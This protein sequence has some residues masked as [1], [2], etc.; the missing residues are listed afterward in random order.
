MASQVKLGSVALAV[1]LCTG[2][3]GEGSRVTQLNTLDGMFQKAVQEAA[4]V[5]K[6]QLHPCRVYPEWDYRYM[7]CFTDS[8]GSALPTAQRL[9]AA[10]TGA[11]FK[12]VGSG[13]VDSELDRTF[14]LPGSPFTLNMSFDDNEFDWI[15]YQQDVGKVQARPE[16][17]ADARY[18]LLSPAQMAEQM[19]QQYLRYAHLT[20]AQQNQ[21]VKYQPCG[22]STATQASVC[23]TMP[24]T[25]VQVY[26]PFIDLYFAG[27]AAEFQS[28]NS[29]PTFRY[30]YISSFEQDM[31]KDGSLPKDYVPPDLF[32]KEKAGIYTRTH[33]TNHLAFKFTFT[34]TPQGSNAYQVTITATRIP[35]QKK[36]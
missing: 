18:A 15:V 8:S 27:N 5:P 21:Q 20:A 24:M 31:I 3:K 23:L 17:G 29:K 30:R 33:T 7:A 11:G 22:P 34:L 26:Q 36:P 10:L 19:V 4:K 32:V 6:L 25:G 1:L 2:C 13:S 35:V 16:D 28:N 9:S 12:L 14:A